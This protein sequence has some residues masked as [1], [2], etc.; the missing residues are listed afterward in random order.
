MRPPRVPPIPEMARSS[1]HSPLRV[2]LPAAAAFFLSGA[3]A[4][5]YQVSWQR[6][7]AIH[8]GVGIYSIAAAFMTGL[9]LGSHWGGRI[10]VRLG[11]RGALAGFAG[12]E[13]AVAAFAA[14]SPWLYYGWWYDR[15]PVLYS[16]PW[17]AGLLHFLALVAPTILMG[18]S[19]PFLVRAMVVDV[20]R[21]SRAI[22]TLY[23]LNVLGASVG[24]ALTPWVLIRFL[25]VA[26]AIFV[27]VG[28]N[29][30]AAALA[31]LIHRRLPEQDPPVAETGP[32][33]QPG[34]AGQPL[35]LWLALYALSGFLAL[36]MEIVWFRLIDVGTKA[37]AFT[38]GTVLA[39]YL[40]GLGAGSLLGD[41]VLARRSD[42]LRVFL[43]CQCVALLWSGL[44]IV[45][46]A[47]LPPDLPGYRWFAEYWGMR[48]G[49]RLG[50]GW[51]AGSFLRLYVL[52]PVALYGVPTFLMGVCFVALQRAVQ[53]DPR[54]SG[55]KVGA[56]QAA[57]IAGCAAGSLATGLGLLSWLGSTGT[58]KVLVGSGVVFAAIGALRSR[59]RRS[60][61]GL[62]VALLLVTA[63]L[64]GQERLWSRLHGATSGAL[65]EEDATAVIAL[66]PQPRGEW[67]MWMGGQSQ[68]SLPFGGTHTL[69]GAIPAILHPA[70]R[71]VA[72]LGLGSGDTAW[73]SGCREETRS[74]VVWEL[75]SPQ[76]RLLRRVASASQPGLGRLAGLLEDP[77]LRVVTGDGRRALHARTERFDLIET[78]ALLPYVA[79]S[80]H[81]YS[82]EFFQI[83]ARRLREGGLM[84]TWAPTRRVVAT[85][86]AVFPHVVAFRNSSILVGSLD[87]IHV[88]PREWVRRASSPRV[89]E[90]LGPE[91][92]SDLIQKLALPRPIT[93]DD[94]AGV[95]PNRDL[96]P[97]D[98]FLRP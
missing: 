48:R 42:P 26:G 92:S 91:A 94:V 24:A 29:V 49:F 89:R 69:L 73:A 14:L 59:P 21:A 12:L 60:F 77:R 45:A 72:I 95:E 82:L 87:R 81:V 80:G 97:R 46:V 58:L 68:S 6:I 3:A 85:F 39:V 44:A 43:T 20:A 75:S 32:P 35:S 53:D 2:V 86:A 56:L 38:F 93:P 41:R 36:S 7:L 98:E 63:L 88:T 30:T 28:A 83:A 61:F 54:T 1:P 16:V 96:D 40:L 66:T 17:Q 13:L 18:M 33:P 51:E 8:S 90:Y 65:V 70:P 19:L 67:W 52:G 22:G 57:N 84:C 76:R 64:P 11:P 50:T 37:T 4:L 10:S 9:G 34:G 15:A 27:G 71:D 74:I 78:D 55:L 47:T 5:A 31:A 25:G 23:G 62:A 79:G